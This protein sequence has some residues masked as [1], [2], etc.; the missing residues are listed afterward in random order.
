MSRSLTYAVIFIFSAVSFVLEAQQIP[1][2][3]YTIHQGLPQNS[4]FDIEQDSYG[5][6]W[7]ATQIGA[8][9]FDGREFLNFSVADGL[10]ENYI[11]QL[12]SDS[13]QRMWF[14][15]EGGGVAR[16]DGEKF[17]V[18]D[19]AMG[20]VDDHVEGLHE[21]RRGNVWIRTHYGISR[22]SSDDSIVTFTRK[23]GLIHNNAICMYEDDKGRMWIGTQEGISVFDGDSIRNIDL[24]DVIWGI[25]QDSEGNYWIATQESGIYRYD[26]NKFSH[27]TT[28]DGLCSDIVISIK[29]DSKD[30]VWCGTYRGG[31]SVYD[32]K[33]FVTHRENGIGGQVIM[34]LFEDSRGNLWARPS[35]NGVYRLRKDVFQ[36]LDKRNGLVDN[37]V[38][39]IFE[40][41]Q[42]NL[43]FGTLGGVSKYSKF[44]FEVFRDSDGL[45]GNNIFSVM[46]DRDG[47]VWA[48]SNAGI[49]MYNRRQFGKWGKKEGLPDFTVTAILQDRQGN[50]W[51]AG[52]STLSLV[53]KERVEVFSDTSVLDQKIIYDLA[54]DDSGR[55]WCATEQGIYCFRDLHFSDPFRG[56]PIMKEDV[57]GIMVRGD[58]LWAA[59]GNGVYACTFRTG[60]WRHWTVDDGLA[61]SKCRDIAA[62]EKGTVW[63]ATDGGLSG[64]MQENG[65]DTIRNFTKKE[66][67]T[68]NTLYFVI[69][70][71]LGRIWT[72]HEKGLD[73][74]DLSTGKIRSYG[75]LDGF[76]PL[77]TNQGAVAVDGK[78]NLWIGTVSGLA[79]YDPAY[80]I[81]STAP[82]LTFI[83]RILLFGKEVDFT[84][85]CDSLDPHSHLPVN[86]MLP[87][88]RNNLTFEFIGLQYTIPEEVSYRY[89]LKGFD[90]E[91]SPETSD[92]T[93]TYRKIPP[94]QYTFMVQARSYAGVWNEHPATF[95][96][97]ISPPFWQTAW[98]V[99][100]MILLG[101]FLVIQIIRIRE[102]QLIREKRILEEKVRLRTEKIEKQKEELES[103]R[104][105]IALQNREIKDS[106]HYARRI[107]SAVLPDL[108]AVSGMLKDYFILFRPRDIV[109]GDFYWMY[110][111]HNKV[112]VVAADC[113]GHGVPGAFMSML[114]VSLLSEVVNR[115][116]IFQANLI[117]NRLRDYIKGVLGQTGKIDEAKD[118][119]DMALVILDYDKGEI[120]YAG[121]YNPLVLIRDG[122][123]LEYKG[124]KMPIGIQ[125]NEK[126]SF[127]NHIIPMRPGDTLY[128]FSD[129]YADQF[130]GE[131]GGKFKIRHFKQL[132]LDIHRKPMAEQKKILEEVLLR[133]MGDLPQVDDILVVGLRP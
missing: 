121:A 68:S 32:G 55:I 36:H 20:L 91:W 25:D 47:N 17:T 125:V 123:L 11:N 97:R 29:V 63:V 108:S 124:D 110:K 100:L 15:T 101:I 113:T 99:G 72:G 46:V 51:A 42:H 39:K 115:D 6:I 83:R 131:D 111:E 27:F 77:E 70:D 90:R 57:R 98:F 80:E 3:N 2:D 67:L 43:W 81:R 130:G 45:M 54:E 94:G 78:H 16:F 9:R 88:N 58:R 56:A 119:M 65:R 126:A 61:Y 62:D 79:H 10:P 105:K 76:I 38:L 24:Q 49:S 37:Y 59:T 103:Q 89:F 5:Y 52:F 95:S 21:D 106:I 87:Y 117:L 4:V 12:M 102:K 34:Q 31:V 30:R 109:S 33:R 127:T 133:W 120:Q 66:G 107:Q 50:V 60:E 18:F 74:L 8:S 129:G 104:D 13:R 64:I 44:T 14:G 118:G 92:N 116:R 132:L 23:N 128:I 69:S 41:N 26:G 85:Y 73:R 84:P 40:D 71:G 93:V 22:I 86:L 114:G 19:H 122:E 96:F 1:F 112:I 28:A 53:G 48:G 7:L 35:E 82:P 75:V